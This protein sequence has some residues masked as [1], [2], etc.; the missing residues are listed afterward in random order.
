MSAVPYFVNGERVTRREYVEHVRQQDRQ[1]AL[2]VLKAA[3]TGQDLDDQQ[4]TQPQE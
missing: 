4:P 3:A 1:Q 2:G